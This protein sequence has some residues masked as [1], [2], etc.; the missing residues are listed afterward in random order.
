M[1]G[2]KK[3]TLSSTAFA[4]SVAVA[5]IISALY[6]YNIFKW[7]NYPDFGYGFR[8]ATGIYVV[9]V[10]TENG[11]RAG[12]QIGDHIREIN[13]KTFSNIE[14]FRAN[15]HRELGETNTY[16]L[17]RQGR[18]FA[19]TIKNIPSGLKRAFRQSGLP[20]VIGL[21][22][23]FIGILVFLMKPHQRPSWIFFLYGSIFGLLLTFLYQIG[24]T[25]PVWFQNFNIISYCFT[26]AVYIH[27]ALS[28]PEERRLLQ[29]HPYTQAIPYLI[30]LVLF[31]L[32]R[33]ESAVMAYAPKHWLVTG[34]VYIAFGVLFFLGSCLQLRLKSKSQIVKLRSRIILL[35]FAIAA[36]IPLMD[37]V[38]NALFGVYLLPNINYMLPF[39]IIFPASIG[40]AIVKHDLFDIDAII[41]RT[42]GYV[43]TTGAIAGLYGIFVLISNL[44]FGSFEFAKTPVFP[45][46]FLLAI[47]FLFNP[48]RNRVQRFIDRVFYRLEY[49]YQET[50]Q[51]IS[52]SMRTLMG[53][54]LIGRS[55]M[56]TARGAMFIDSGAVMLKRKDENEYSCLIH[57]GEKDVKLAGVGTNEATAAVD[58]A[59]SKTAGVATAAEN[60]EQSQAIDKGTKKADEES[61]A[62]K[63]D[64]PTLSLD[65]PLIQKMAKQKKEVTVYDIQ[66]DPFFE[67]ERE[68]C[69]KV[70]DQLDATLL[71]PLIY[72]DQLIGLISLGRKRSGKFYRRDDINL[73]NILANQGAVAIENA[74]M[75]EEVIEKER[76]EEELSIAR[77]LQVSMLPATCPKVEGVEL[78]A[79]SV[80]AREVG[81]DFFDFIEMDAKKVGMLIGDVTGKSVS[82]AL[83]MSAS[84]SIFR[85]LSEEERSVAEN[86]IRA[87]KRI[88][89]DVRTGMFV[90]L[91]YAVLD[92]RD[93]TLTLCSAG[94]TQ[95]VFLDGKTGETFLVE[96]KGDKFPLG[97]L[98]EAAYE[99]TRLQLKPGDKV[100]FYTDGIVEAMNGQREIY[101]FDRL[102]EIVKISDTTSADALMEQIVENVKNFVGEAPQ[103]DDLTLIV[104]SVTKNN[105]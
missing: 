28:F 29:K 90:A 4:L 74:L 55:I 96:T 39:I 80:S 57:A 59:I 41:K 49:D 73:L 23:T 67:G 93:R 38:F 20:Y 87:N 11:Q 13:S 32:I 16:L 75:L 42:Y 33:R 18:T 94:Q 46:I 17:D 103:H 51:Q 92:A 95:P 88:K 85:M 19:V 78:A 52:E 83:V 35:G 77:D 6:L 60:T 36:S 3:N 104:L 37:Y 21:C 8:S 63:P 82:G 66:E 89:K 53:L 26:P 44:A 69:Q 22:Y 45:L 102:L 48:I 99:E 65:E 72:E 56:D 2:K 97:I 43:L 30:S 1:I 70:F 98:E 54:D 62:L 27:L 86:M 100:I 7:A 84:R 58:D 25:T 79:F 50:V 40:Y 71:V 64:L 12:M 105:R 68:S 101:G 81:G 31:V 9:G 10:L 47:V 76:M 14:E 24:P 15:M 34:M 91:L 5:L 61:K